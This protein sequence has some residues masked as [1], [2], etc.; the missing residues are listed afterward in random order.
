M[1]K[2]MNEKMDGAH[3]KMDGMHDKMKH[4]VNDQI[5]HHMG[6]RKK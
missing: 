2:T 4:K 1:K 5:D 3:D 6:W